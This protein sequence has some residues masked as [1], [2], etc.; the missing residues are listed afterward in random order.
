MEPFENPLF[1][2]IHSF[3]HRQFPEKPLKIWGFLRV[4]KKLHKSGPPFFVE[5]RRHKSGKISRSCSVS[6]HNICTY[7]VSIGV[8]LG[9]P[10]LRIKRLHLTRKA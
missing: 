4:A 8:N 9:L 6:L 10:N 1:H 3:I 5:K 7:F 2:T